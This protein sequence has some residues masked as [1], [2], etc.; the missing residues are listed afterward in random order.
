MSD[1]APKPRD[2]SKTPSWI[3]VGFLLGVAALLGFQAQ[4]RRWE[5]RAAAENPPPPLVV[6]SPPAPP[7]ALLEAVRRGPPLAEV[8]A[9]FRA[10]E[11]HAQ[12]TPELTTEVALW[13]EQVG[14]FAHAFEV[15]RV[16]DEVFFRSIDGLTRDTVSDG[17]AEGSPIVFTENPD[18]RVRRIEEARRIDER[19]RDLVPG[20][21]RQP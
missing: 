13:S 21:A 1:A 3:M 17:L 10:W 4:M 16:G 7:S 18:R 14:R 9:A 6:P 20:A 5:R 11:K 15:V 12:W 8:E 2:L 19:V